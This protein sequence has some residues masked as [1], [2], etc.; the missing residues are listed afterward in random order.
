[1]KQVGSESLIPDRAVAASHLQRAP[2]LGTCRE[3]R[4]PAQPRHELSDLPSVLDH[5]LPACR[6]QPGP[7]DVLGLPYVSSSC[8][9]SS[10]S[11]LLYLPRQKMARLVAQL[12][13]HK[14]ELP[15]TPRLG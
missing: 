11:N 12:N 3:L 6:T 14:G 5:R 2:G 10:T 8:F 4:S 13:Q 1:M 9:P 7:E 15:W